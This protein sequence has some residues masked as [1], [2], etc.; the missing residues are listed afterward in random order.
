MLT[1]SCDGCPASAATLELAIKEAL[2][3]AAPDMAGLEVEGVVAAA[4]PPAPAGI[5]L[6]VVQPNGN[7][8]GGAAAPTG[9]I[10]LS[11]P[12][13]GPIRHDRSSR[14]LALDGPTPAD[15]E[16]SRQVVD[17]TPIVVANVGD[18][19]LAFRDACA[20]CGEPIAGG[21]LKGGVLDCPACER[22][23]YL[24]RAGRSMDEAKLLL[25][26]VPLLSSG[27]AVTVAVVSGQS[28][29]S[30]ADSASENQASRGRREAQ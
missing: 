7:G 8:N 14:W 2:E 15:G 11:A 24:P 9:P 27:G 26:P 29:K 3:K 28:G 6:P 13:A 19:L 16:V 23:F 25:E 4:P 20:A 5:E 17:G 30:R 22:R 10:E 1:G 12:N 18:S 21:K